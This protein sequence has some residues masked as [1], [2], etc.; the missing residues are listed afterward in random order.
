VSTCKD[1]LQVQSEAGRNAERKCK[2]L[3]QGWT[4]NRDRFEAN[5]SELEAALALVRKTA[6]SPELGV[7]AGRGLVDIVARYAQT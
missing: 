7:E 5:A 4:L 6:Q 1:F 3:A 2:H